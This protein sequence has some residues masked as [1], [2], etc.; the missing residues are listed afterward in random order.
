M[1]RTV[2]KRPTTPCVLWVGRK[3]TNG[4]GRRRIQG[5]EFYAHRLAYEAARGPIPAGLVI[6]HLCEAPACV[7]PDH[8][9]PVT[10]HENIRRSWP[11]GLPVSPH[12]ACEVNRTKTHCRSGHALGGRNLIVKHNGD[13]SQERVC[14]ECRNAGGRAS[15]ARGGGHHYKAAK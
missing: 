4:Y 1:P 6:D 2:D 14:R 11:N 9:E 10:I 5:R 8:M 13:G 15:Y 7:N 12:N 3:D